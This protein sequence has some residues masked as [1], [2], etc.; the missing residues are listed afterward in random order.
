MATTNGRQPGVSRSGLRATWSP[1]QQLI[2]TARIRS[3]E[4]ATKSS[5]GTFH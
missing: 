3:H 2:G 1:A 4:A 5:Q